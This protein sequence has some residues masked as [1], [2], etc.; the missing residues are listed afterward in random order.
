MR[1]HRKPDGTPIPFS[2]EEEAKR[3]EMEA[4]F[5]AVSPRESIR[6]AWQAQPVAVRAAFSVTYAA[7]NTALDQGDFELAVYLVNA[8]Q[9]PP[10][11]EATKSQLLTLVEA[12]S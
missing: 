9:V 5:S 7:V 12:I 6:L 2:A 3:D 1:Y 10:E 11:M 8:A 4:T